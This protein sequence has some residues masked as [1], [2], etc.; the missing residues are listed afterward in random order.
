MLAHGPVQLAP[1]RVDDLAEVGEFLHAHL[2]PRLGPSEWARS[3]VPTWP[4]S[5]PNH[6]FLLRDESAGGRVVGTQLAFY[7]KRVIDGTDQD[8]CNLGA[9]CVL[10]DYRSH[11]LRLL[12]AVLAQR[13]Y[14]F[15]DLSPSGNV[16]A[17]NRTLGFEPL[18]TTTALVA[19][20]PV[21]RR[22]GARVLADLAELGRVLTGEDLRIFEDHREAAATIHLALFQGEDHCYVVV[23]RDRRK[24]LPVFASLLHIGAP[25]LLRRNL[26]V[27]GQHLLIRHGL[28]CSLVELRLLGSQPA[29]SV[30][31][32]SPRPKMFRSA[33]HAPVQAASVDNLYSEL[34]LVAW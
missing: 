11:G 12:R 8:F 24:N 18:D 25:E 34:T 7:S 23:R 2:N 29:G 27:L 16:V 26:A 19:N 20:H 33:R 21:I 9:W 30:L 32:R 6:G 14:H 22:R 15:T 13:Q 3:V 28:L 5:S 17:L 31:L 1:I 10:D 4:V